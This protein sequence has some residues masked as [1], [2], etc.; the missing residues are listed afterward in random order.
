V[1]KQLISTIDRCNINDVEYDRTV[2]YAYIIETSLEL[3]SAISDKREGMRHRLCSESGDR[4][5]FSGGSTSLSF[6]QEEV[7]SFLWCTE[8]ISRINSYL[9]FLFSDSR[10]GGHYGF[11]KGNNDQRLPCNQ[12]MHLRHGRSSNQHSKL[13]KTHINSL[14]N[15]ARKTSTLNVPTTSFQNTTALISPGL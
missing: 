9:H 3:V 12:S 1:R 5:V 15:I 4:Q 14:L 2:E 8:R 13:P 10:I 6:K 7:P 11:P